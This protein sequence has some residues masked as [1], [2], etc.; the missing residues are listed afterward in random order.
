M[1]IDNGLVLKP[2]HVKSKSETGED[3]DFSLQRKDELI[4]KL[5]LRR[6][7]RRRKR[8]KGEEI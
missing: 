3:E 2:P 7:G 5:G 8:Q 4:L 1:C 6:R